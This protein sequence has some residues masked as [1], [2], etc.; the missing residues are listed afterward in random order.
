MLT[1]SERQEI[2]QR[3]R[4]AVDKAQAAHR[5]AGGRFDRLVN[6]SPSG[7]PQPDGALHIQQVGRDSRSAL[8]Q[9][10]HALKRFTEFT[11][12]GTIPEDI[13]PRS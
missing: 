11:L 9:Y 6:E 1:Y 3:L 12:Y 5:A 10:K 4:E 7:F 2:R 13:L 8:Q